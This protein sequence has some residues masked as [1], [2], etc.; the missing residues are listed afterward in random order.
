M[1]PG[2]CSATTVLLIFIF[3]CINNIY[4]KTTRVSKPVRIPGSY[5]EVVEE[6]TCSEGVIRLTCR[7]L[8]AFLFILE[9]QYYRNEAENCYEVTKV[10]RAIRHKEYWSRYRGNTTVELKGNYIHGD[11]EHKP[12]VDLRT[13]FNRRCS[14]HHH[15][16]FNISEDHPGP[17]RWQP[18]NLRLKYACILETA[19]RKYCN[20]EVKLNNNEGGYIKTPGYPLYYPGE[21]ACVWTFQTI[22]GQRV[23]LQFHDFNIRSPE[24]NGNCVDVVRIRENGKTLFESCGT[25]AGTRIISESNKITLDLMSASKVFPARGLLLQYQ[26]IGCPA[27]Q[28]PNGSFISNDTFSSR[29]F[30]CRSGTVFPDTMQSTRTLDCQKGHWNESIDNLPNCVASSAIIL[31]AKEDDNHLVSLSGDNI[32]NTGVRIGRTDNAVVVESVLGMDSAQTNM[33]KQADFVVDMVVPSILIVLLF[34]GNAVI[35]YIIFQYRK[36]KVPTISSGE[37]MALRP[38]TDVPQV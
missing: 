19:V 28:T 26:A 7:S 24:S 22:P 6:V 9:A 1:Q 16:R 18:A 10:K 5:I 8:R 34:V 36:R 14:G 3:L 11:D 37:E 21:Y 13:S 32:H 35:V 38:P 31:K 12:V 29:T 25:R 23:S 27:I 17:S 15:C 20:T 33:M 4:G 2:R 30:E